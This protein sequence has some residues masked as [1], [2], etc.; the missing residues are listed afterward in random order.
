MLGPP[1]PAWGTR[2]GVLSSPPPLRGCPLPWVPPPP[3]AKSSLINEGLIRIN[4]GLIRVSAWAEGAGFIPE[5]RL[6]AGSSGTLW[7]QP[8]PLAGPCP[9]LPFSTSRFIFPSFFSFLQLSHSSRL[10]SSF[11]AEFSQL[12][13]CQHGRYG[14]FHGGL[15]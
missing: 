4:E 7:F 9:L 11:P 6:W 13:V 10:L 3:V 2:V 15:G 5:T 1:Q 8:L 12:R 14:V